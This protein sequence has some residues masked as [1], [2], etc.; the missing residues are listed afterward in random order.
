MGKHPGRVNVSLDR[1]RSCFPDCNRL[2]QI[3]AVTETLWILLAVFQLVPHV[4]R[5]GVASVSQPKQD[6]VGSGRETHRLSSS[7][8]KNK[9]Q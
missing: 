1:W 5:H 9:K 4:F 2:S 3:S 8:V 7:P 6:S